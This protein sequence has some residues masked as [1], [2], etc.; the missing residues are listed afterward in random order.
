M[1]TESIN[2]RIDNTPALGLDVFKGRREGLLKGVTENNYLL[3]YYWSWEQCAAFYAATVAVLLA[4]SMLDEYE[5]ALHEKGLWQGNAKNC[6][7]MARRAATRWEESIFGGKS[8]PKFRFFLRHA[9]ENISPRMLAYKTFYKVD[10]FNFLSRY[11]CTHSK[12]LSVHYAINEFASY[13]C[14]A[15]KG[16]GLDERFAPVEMMKAVWN[17]I[18]GLHYGAEQEIRY[19][20]SKELS[21]LR[22]AMTQKMAED[23]DK[24]MRAI[25]EGW[26]AESGQEFGKTV[27]Q[28]QEEA[29]RLG[30][31]G[32]D[33]PS[34]QLSRRQ[35]RALDRVSKKRR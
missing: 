14:A 21:D 30:Q 10:V 24:E 9:R 18:T 11:G 17:S 27:G 2:T 33:V 13:A 12:V 31:Y 35:R 28:I 25:M 32:D 29:M 8:L 34:R 7:Y 23:T 1:D 26:R 5:D 15:I 20:D 22:E 6:V 3:N 4:K 19:G 16:V